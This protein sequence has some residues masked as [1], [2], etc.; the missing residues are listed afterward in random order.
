MSKSDKIKRTKVIQLRVS[1]DEKAIIQKHAN[2]NVS[3]WLRAYGLNPK[4]PH[5]KPQYRELKQDPE[6]VR[7]LA[8]IGNNLNQLAR[9][10]NTIKKSGGALNLVAVQAK[11]LQANELLEQIAKPQR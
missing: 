10:I 3:D 9:Q 4:N 2:G 5:H 1:E 7:Q 8:F 11:L 6:V